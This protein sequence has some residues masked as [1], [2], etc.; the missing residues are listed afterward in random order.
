M[1]KGK[2]TIEELLEE[3]IVP[4]EEKPYEV[5]DN[6]V[7]V[8]M[9]DIIKIN[10][11]KPK[12][13]LPHEQFCSFLPMN[14]VNPETGKIDSLEEREFEKVK[15]GYTYFEE[16][17]V[18]FAKITPCMENGN[19]VIA[20]G[21]IN[22][23]GFGSTEFY[24]FRTP[25]KIDERY[26]YFLL[27]S[28]KFRKQ[29]KVEMTGAVGQQRVPKKFL[30]SY[31]LALPPLNEQKRIAEKVERLLNKIEE[32]RQLIEN[33]PE[34]LNRLKLSVLHDACT[35]RLTVDWRRANGIEGAIIS[36]NREG[37][38]NITNSW[39]I[40]KLKEIS[41]MVSVGHVGKTTEYYCDE[42]I[43]VPFIRS[44]NVRPG[45]LDL[46]EVKYITKDF[47]NKLKKSQLKA[48]DLLVV[49]VGAN[50]GDSCIVPDGVEQ[51]NCANI[52][53]A[54]PKKG[55][56]AYL[57]LYFQSNISQ[58]LLLGASTGSA[59]G[60]I[61]TKRVAE[62]TVPLP[63]EEEQKVIVERVKRIFNSIEKILKGYEQLVQSNENAYHSILSKAF[64]GEL[65]T[66]DP[67]EEN[68]IEL[69]KEV[70]Q[71]QVE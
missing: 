48:G 38:L 10:P 43:G 53:F 33:I 50:R 4:E 70:L 26:L 36:S 56:S 15:K 45:K 37:L 8:K 47:H 64:R 13:D 2:K 7:W 46:K 55:L 23:F 51:L 20:K 12:L 19:T 65:G 31:P 22:K 68:A 44:Q 11:P 24:V 5:P 35:G 17:D 69:L 58:N 52:V 25:E 63:P 16:N 3:T 34:A 57:N 27:R 60:V 18:L 71:E 42:S 66:N 67:S 41:E 32:A 6:W 54:R 62:I 14:L 30:E 59:Q 49:R 39:S 61:N 40:K 28:E 1:S 21:L 9:G 29:A